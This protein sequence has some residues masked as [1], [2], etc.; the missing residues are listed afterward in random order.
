MATFMYYFNFMT[1]LRFLD[2]ESNVFVDISKSTFQ[3][4]KFDLSIDS[5]CHM[6]HFG[7]IFTVNIVLYPL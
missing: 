7:S 4:I 6:Y 2:I 1:F 3:K 5:Y